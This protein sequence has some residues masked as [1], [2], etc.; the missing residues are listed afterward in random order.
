[1]RKWLD[2][3]NLKTLTVLT[4]IALGITATFIHFSHVSQSLLWKSLTA[5]AAILFSV[6]FLIVSNATLQKTN[7]A[8]KKA[9]GILLFFSFLGIIL[10]FFVASYL[11]GG[12]DVLLLLPLSE[13]LMYWVYIRESFIETQPNDSEQVQLR[14]ENLKNY[15][16]KRVNLMFTLV[17]VFAVLPLLFIKGIVLPVPAT[18]GALYSVSLTVYA[19]IFSVVTA[20][21][22]LGL[23]RDET[24]SRKGA[25]E[26]PLLGLAHMCVVFFLI[27]LVGTVLGIDVDTTLFAAGTTLGE[28]L[29]L[30]TLGVGVI[31]VLLIESIIISFPFTLVYLYAILRTF[32]SDQ[33]GST[34]KT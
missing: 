30:E 17:F 24:N 23:G 7:F 33:L 8:K 13:L 29:S 10:I 20:F 19:I 21:G 2:K 1:M 32:L 5:A 26:R 16:R 4:F 6:L 3:R 22:V 25:L 27:S 34:E 14:I 31:R 11:M 15:L 18:F 28:A 9:S 12:T